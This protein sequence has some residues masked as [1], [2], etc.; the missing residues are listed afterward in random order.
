MAWLSVAAILLVLPMGS[1]TNKKMETSVLLWDLGAGFDT[2]NL[3]PL[4]KASNLW[5]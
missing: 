4:L 1:I 2:Q 5:V 3:H